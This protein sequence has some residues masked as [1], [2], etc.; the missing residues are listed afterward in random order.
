MLPTTL[1]LPFARLF[2][3]LTAGLFLLLAPAA[4]CVPQWLPGDPRPV[5]DGYTTSS[6]IWDPD[7][8]GPLTA[9]LLVGGGMKVANNNQEDVL[10]YDGSTWAPLGSANGYVTALI[11][12]NGQPYAA[13]TESPSF[14]STIRT[15]DGTAWQPI[16]L[17]S[18]PV[19]SFAIF[20]GQLVAGGS[21]T[22]VAG[23]AASN[24]ASWN[25]TSWNPL[26][27]GIGNG[28]VRAMA[29]FN[30]T[31]RV[32]GQFTIAGGQAAGNLAIWTGT[33][34]TIGPI[35]NGDVHAIAVRSTTTIATTL[36][37]V[38]GAFTSYSIGGLATAAQHIARFEG[39]NNTWSAVGTGVP[40]T[41]CTALFARN[42]GLSSYEVIAGVEDAN[43]AQHAFRLNAGVWTPMGTLPNEAYN[44]HPATITFFGGRHT[45]GISTSTHA[46]RSWDGTQWLDVNGQGIL[47]T[48]YAVEPSGNDI[49]IGGAFATIGGVAMNGIARGSA[50]AWTPLGTGMTGG[51]G[52][53]ALAT[54]QNGDVVAGGDFTTAGGL[55]AN[56]IARW[57]GVAWAPLGTGLDAT[58]T[59]L[60]ALPG[61]DILAAGDF[62]SAGGVP[63]SRIARWNG[64]TWTA[65][66]L[67]LSA[68]VNALAQLQ[69]GDI[70]AGG[71]FLQA[72]V[73]PV[74]RIARWNG[75][76]WF[77]LGSGCNDSV[78]ALATAPNGV[79]YAGG[80]FTAAGAAASRLVSWSNGTWS[81]VTA[82]GIN[83][84]VL[85][86]AVHA[87]G[88]LFVGGGVFSF[89]FG[90]FGS[91]YSNLVRISP[92]GTLWSMGVA[93]VTVRGIALPS[94]DVAIGGQ[95]TSMGAVVSVNVARYHTPCAATAT[96]YGAGCSGLAAP[97]S[98]ASLEAPWIGGSYRLRASTFGPT[99]F[100]VQALGLAQL[101][102]P[103]PPL[104]PGALPGCLGLVTPDSLTVAFPTLGVLT[105]GSAVPLTA[106]L[107]GF[108]L[109]AQVVQFEPLGGSFAISSSNGL[110]MTVGSL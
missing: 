47:G 67:G 16:G 14:W 25:G 65:L 83:T 69:N 3:A 29:V 101:S 95:F 72:G 49:V 105:F 53:F 19:Y 8:A 103:L 54:A 42:L 97:L 90:P 7:G 4:Q 73:V 6:A 55:P 30:N 75:S 107:I 51:L 27:V 31:L 110:H 22:T 36:L 88:H 108:Q 33:A 13:F 99:G 89:S 96:S 41:R 78:Y 61:G 17:A 98:L 74:N 11:V 109:N 1:R 102:L 76:T 2:T 21:F 87:N 66:G 12:W 50:N 32:G 39:Q 93:G 18:G 48:V 57:N 106:A 91:W 24:I 82:I 71:D 79:L 60:L 40:G 92:S 64:S 5:P 100:A 20:N 85:A 37:F 45:I 15:W 35:F 58:V 62:T 52:V 104:L 63:A 56:R 46:V 43:S 80:R 26:G 86:L 77:A 94:G 10:A 44:V 68:R 28:S 34:W 81:P 84:D 38:G 9:R 59:A 23:V 70:V